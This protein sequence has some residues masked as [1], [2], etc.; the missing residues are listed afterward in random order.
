[1]F[2][3]DTPDVTLILPLRSEVGWPVTVFNGT[4][5]VPADVTVRNAAGDEVPE[6]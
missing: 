2:D 3:D 4:E 6:V 5:E 1:M